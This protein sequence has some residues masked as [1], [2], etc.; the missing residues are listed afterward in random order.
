MLA[1]VSFIEHAREC[2]PQATPRVHDFY[3][4][5]ERRLTYDARTSSLM[6]DVA[7]EIGGR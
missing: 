2:S 7:V 5:F 1:S 3:L 6:A 4:A